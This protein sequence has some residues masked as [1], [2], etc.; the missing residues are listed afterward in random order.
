MRRGQLKEIERYAKSQMMR[1]GLYGWPHVKR[2]ESLCMLIQKHESV[3][4]DV[5]LVVLKVAALLHDIAKYVEKKSPKDHGEI[6]GIMA[7]SFLKTI[8]FD[9]AKAELIC[10]AIRA[11]THT[12]KPMSIEAKILHDAD[13]LD[14]LGA[15]GI[16]SVF[17]KACLTDKTIEQV[18]EM[19]CSE[20]SKSSYVAKHI[21]WLKRQHFYTETARRIAGQRNEIVAAFFKALKSELNCNTNWR[22]HFSNCSQGA[23]E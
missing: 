21:H 14:K 19:Y 1:L 12:E 13:F 11:H 6:G 2:V 9:R 17:I 8:G 7:Q 16:A 18:A 22:S 20:R 15:V 4:N 5:D 23:T 3:R 10:H